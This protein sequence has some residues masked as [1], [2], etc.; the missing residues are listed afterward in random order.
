MRHIA[1]V[2]SVALSA[3]AQ[4]QT[5]ARSVAIPRLDA[6]ITVD[7]TLDEPVW[8]QAT[9]LD[10]FRQYLPSD[11][12]PAQEKTEVLVWYAPDAL[13][14]GIRAFT[15]DVASLRATRAD[16]DK[17]DNDDR[18][19]LYLDTFN[20]RR[21]A[22]MFGVNALG[23][24]L[25]G[26]R[27][28]G[29]SSATRMFGGNIDYNPDFYYQSRG[30]LT[31][32]GYEVEL[33]IP[34]KSL[35][36]P[37][38][39]EQAWGFNAHRFSPSTGYEDTWTDV[40]RAGASFI[41]QGGTLTGLHDLERGVVT[42]VQPF[43]T[44]TQAG[45]RDAAGDFTRGNTIMTAGANVRLGFTQLSL[46]ATFNPDF[47]QVESDAGLVT[48]NERFALFI[49]EKR[50]FFLEGI[51]LFATPNQLVYTRQLV[52]PSVGGKVTGKLGAYS[53]ALL[54]AQDH[55]RA[56]NAQFQIG[57]LRRDLGAGS[58]V[59]LTVTDKERE[60]AYNRV[61][62]ADLRWVHHK[63]YYFEGQL[64]TAATRNA[65]GSA[66]Q[67]AIWKVEHDR[68]GRHWGYNFQ[69]TDIGREFQSQAGFVPRTNVTSWR[70]FNR[71]SW[72][73]APGA[74]L[75]SVTTFF[76]P[77]RIWR[78]GGALSSAPLEGKEN[79][80]LMVRLRGGWNITTQT[81]R[82]FFFV[83]PAAYARYTIDSGSTALLYRPASWQ[84]GLADVGATI[85]SPVLQRVNASLSVQ[86][87]TSP[88]FAEGSR[89]T[90]LR[91]SGSLTL[92]P[93]S[94]ARV[95]ATLASSRI[96]RRLDGS[97]Y[98]R[99]LIP[100]VKAEYQITRVMFVRVVGEYR[101]E[102]RDALR[103]ADDG[104]TLWVNQTR[105][106]PTASSRLRMDWLA[107]YQPTPGTVAFFGYGSGR[108]A[109]GADGFSDLRRSDDAFFV[110]LAYQFRR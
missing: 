13:M 73:G 80:S 82:Q 106:V 22:F 83:D 54:S 96:T 93:T 47:S 10:G 14:V 53:V 29:A 98:A 109:P 60:G 75:E 9:L 57:R 77:T 7:G 67:G 91:I 1:L 15:A 21:R 108:V 30:R 74:M 20:D 64:G 2:L 100:R 86:R 39:G 41:A 66:Q 32:Q 46:D 45:A 36:L 23:V 88:I 8:G 50:P 4:A 68:T 58:N 69:W 49:P 72:Y 42:E 43:V 3:V 16:R 25:D 19:I 102:R 95:D 34:F 107:S 26:V 11:S 70:W 97:E 35:R 37:G 44:A 62:A 101:S 71:L 110:K 79:I 61:V 38:T 31:A 12:R 103:A 76:G 18:I 63:L 85:S 59:G 78:S 104:R 65:A 90:D 48:L 84:S 6:R 94:A 81:G 40:R 52:D 55:Q 89:G 87:T 105:S 33:R 17:I 24:Q 56:G 99:T 92:R 28:E 51:E 27:T 5:A